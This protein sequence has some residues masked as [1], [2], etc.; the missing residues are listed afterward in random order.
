M[1]IMLEQSNLS[2]FLQTIQSKKDQ[3][4]K[5]VMCELLGKMNLTLQDIDSKQI[6]RLLKYVEYFM[7]VAGLY[8]F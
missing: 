7:E 5:E 3:N 4:Y 6:D 1:F 2:S 8:T